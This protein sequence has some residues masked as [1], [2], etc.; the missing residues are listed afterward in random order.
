VS[1]QPLELII[2][3]NLI[4]TVSLAAFLVDGDGVIVFFNESAGELI[5]RRFEEVGRLSREDWNSEFGPYDEFGQLL[6][7]DDMP[8][9][10]ALREGL[11]ANGRFK[12]RLGESELT[13]F[14]VSALPLSGTDGFK[15]AIVLF[16][17]AR[18]GT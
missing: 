8:L 18:E 13:D 3:R 5:G 12:V 16:W 1:Q 15:G 7:T 4:S 17:K 10:A 2:A 14:E 11:P 6:P 9:T